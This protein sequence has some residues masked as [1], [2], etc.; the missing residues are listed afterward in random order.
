MSQPAIIMIG[1]MMFFG[2]I[3]TVLILGYTWGW[4]RLKKF[5]PGRGEKL[6]TRASIIIPARNEEQNIQ[7]LLD[8]LLKQQISKQRFEIIVADDQST[9][10]TAEIVESF[11]QKHPELRL[12]LMRITHPNQTTTY[13]KMAISKA[14][15]Q[16]TGELIITTDADCRVEPGWL[17]AILHYYE[18][19]QPKMII[20]PV[21][22]HHEESIFEKMQSLE[23]LSL[24][25]ITG[26]A[27]SIGKPVMCNGANLAYEKEAFYETGG[28]DHDSFASG[29][30]V[31][32]LLK[33]KKKFGSDSI[34][35]LKNLE[36]VVHTRA[37]KTLWDFYHQRTRWASKNKGYDLRILFV[38]FSVYMTNLLI[39][40][41]Y[42]YNIF[43]PA[44]L[45]VTLWATA[46]KI[47]VDIPIL[48][49]I[50]NFVKRNR[51]LLYTIPLIV[52][53]PL[54]IIL[55]GALGVVATYQWKGRKVT[56]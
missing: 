36:A 51:I 17:N 15:S 33:M 9:D 45:P 14:I 11:I 49:G 42:I 34:H 35:F 40:A 8:D 41:A 22:F 21:A 28:F 56:K 23:F 2:L 1:L 12:Q 26:G 32:L 13:K 29:D 55:I 16:S 48:V 39:I 5:V 37:Q 54:Y 19:Y 10:L 3:Y 38:S 25:A 43:N 53:Y 50:T 47:A 27:I 30:D 4:Y 6:S 46:I 7:M 44:F 31:F 24:I 52:F 18:T 20:G